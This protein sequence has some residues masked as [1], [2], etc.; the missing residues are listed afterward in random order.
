MSEEAQDFV[1][2]LYEKHHYDLLK[3]DMQSLIDES[4]EGLTRVRDIVENLKLFSLEN[5]DETKDI[6]INDIANQLIKLVSTQYPEPTY[7]LDIPDKKVEYTGNAGMLKQALMN[8]IVNAA[9]AI[10]GKGFIKITLE[11]IDSAITIKVL[12]SG[13]G[14]PEKH[15]SRIFE[16]FFTTKPEGKGQGLGLSVAYTAIEKHGGKI[17]VNSKERKGTVVTILLPKNA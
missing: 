3:D 1:K 10:E 14:I 17:T 12:D 8:V 7:K 16:P 6:N 15:L 13:I 11:D 4:T 2:S 9:Q 5:N